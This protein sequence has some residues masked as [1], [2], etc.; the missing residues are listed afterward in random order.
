MLLGLALLAGMGIG[1]L[2]QWPLVEEDSVVIQPVSREEMELVVQAQVENVLAGKYPWVLREPAQITAVEPPAPKAPAPEKPK[3]V[4]VISLEELNWP[5]QAEVATPFGWFRHPVYG[6]WR[7]NA[8]IEFNAPGQMVKTVLAGEVVSVTSSDLETE[9]IIDHGSGWASV[10][11]SVKGLTVVP[12]ELVAEG[13]KIATAAD[14]LVF[15]G[16]SHNGA[17]VNPEAFLR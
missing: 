9:L 3:P 6:D 14:G 8:G 12:G 16:L 7:F 17:P 1:I 15:F 10:Y 5:V 11:R 2:R 13:Q 4:A